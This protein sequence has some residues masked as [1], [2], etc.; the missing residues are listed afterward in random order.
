MEEDKN[1]LMNGGWLND[2]VV[3]AGCNFL[4]LLFLIYQDFKTQCCRY[5]MTIANACELCFGGDPSVVKIHPK[6]HEEAFTESI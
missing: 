6:R 1:V 4:K 5:L 3:H 2:R